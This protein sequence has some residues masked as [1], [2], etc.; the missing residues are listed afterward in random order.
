MPI[1]DTLED[2]KSHLKAEDVIVL[3][4]DG[5]LYNSPPP[6]QNIGSATHIGR[7]SST[8]DVSK[9]VDNPASNM[10]GLDTPEGRKKQRRGLE[11]F[12]R[13][14]KKLGTERRR[15]AVP[16]SAALDAKES[17]PHGT[18]YPPPYPPVPQEDPLPRQYSPPQ[19]YSGSQ[20][21]SLAQVYPLPQGYSQP[22]SYL[23]QQYDPGQKHVM[24]P[25]EP[26]APFYVG[27]V[28]QQP[29][30]PYQQQPGPPMGPYSLY[31]DPNLPQ[32]YG[33]PQKPPGS[34][35]DSGYATMQSSPAP[36]PQNL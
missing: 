31:S 14:M 20:G 26:Q 13:A 23:P 10:T 6:Q 25:F 12:I 27:P 28:P 9:P 19:Q 29:F 3:P 24:D 15:T 34:G 7:S 36:P 5:V 32:W 11:S 18:V 21:Y 4:D 35:L 16:G 22:Q 30:N 8:G 33:E 17:T 2:I 1:H